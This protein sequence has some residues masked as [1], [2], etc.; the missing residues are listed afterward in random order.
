MTIWH[1]HGYT[2][3]VK[4]FFAYFYAVVRTTD[5][6]QVAMTAEVQWEP[7][8]IGDALKAINAHMNEVTK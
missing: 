4:E 8:A 7:T 5:G 2:I 1:Y 3:E 6:T